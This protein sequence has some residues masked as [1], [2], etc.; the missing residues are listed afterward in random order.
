MRDL[1]LKHLRI[2]TAIARTG[3]VL[4]AADALGVTPP[5][6]TLQL[7]QLEQ[8]I[9]LPLFERTR[10]GMVPTAAGALM[11]D[12]A[13]RIDAVTAATAESLDGLRGLHHGRVSVGVVSTAKYFAPAALG[14]FR[15]LHPDIEISLL[16]G[17]REEVIAAL[18]ALACDLV[19]M[20]LP[21]EGLDLVS[22]TL[23][24]HP[25]VVIAPVTHPL[26]R[27][28][29]L[30]LAELAGEDFLMRERGSGTRMLMERLFGAV[31][32]TPQM[33]MEMTSN[34]TIKQAVIA[35]L[36]IAFISGHTIASEVEAGRLAILD[37][38]GLPA[39]RKWQ[40]VRHAEK[41]MMPAAEAL[42]NF[43][44]R[45]GRL[46][47]PPILQHG[48]GRSRASERPAHACSP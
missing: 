2:V 15:R 28:T 48:K 43:L 34:E 45:D 46:F 33:T 39:R 1:T 7:K 30:P 3:K 17:N 13:H 37:V 40:I 23:G 38:A 4:A 16:V 36:G 26:A 6:I 12:A 11:L 27:R 5:A 9:G 21:P 31:G 10:R 25:H 35:G 29:A 47:L 44:E 32:I 24:D 42:W 20:G 14:A 8:M 18:A 19:V 22:A 41:R